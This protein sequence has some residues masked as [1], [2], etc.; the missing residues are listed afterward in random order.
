MTAGYQVHLADAVKKA[1]GLPVIAVGLL[2]DPA[3]AD[4]VLGSGAAD[5]VAVGRGLLRDPYWLLNAQYRQTAA[6]TAP[7]QFVPDSYRRGFGV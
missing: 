2:D 5:L 1:T 4:Y 6:D 3:V 7:L